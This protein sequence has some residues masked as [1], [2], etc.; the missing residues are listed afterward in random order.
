MV[1][2]EYLLHPQ[3]GYPH[4]LR[5][6]VEYLLDDSGLTVRTTA[7]NVGASA[8]PYGAGPIPYLTVGTPTID[9]VTLQARTDG[10]R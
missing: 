9:S 1:R 5:L 8:C 10:N 7:T 4:T 3:P 2:M 6:A